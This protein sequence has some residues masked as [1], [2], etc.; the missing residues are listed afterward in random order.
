MKASQESIANSAIK[1]F[2][3]EQYKGNM[4]NGFMKIAKKVECLLCKAI[5]T[6][7]RYL[8]D[9]VKRIHQPAKN[10]T[11]VQCDKCDKTFYTLQ[12]IRMHLKWIHEKRKEVECHICKVIL[13]NDLGLKNHIRRN[14]LL[15]ENETRV[16][17][18]ICEKT[19]ISSNTKVSH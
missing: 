13:T 10:K 6:N 11:V 15:N 4:S 2:L 5:L 3:H 16:Q 17:C 18:E 1:L 19:F 14:H 9:H 8:K 7:K 12:T